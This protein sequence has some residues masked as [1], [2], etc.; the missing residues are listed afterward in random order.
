M[1]FLL[2]S[3]LTLLHNSQQRNLVIAEA[4]GTKVSGAIGEIWNILAQYLNFT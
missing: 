4:N 3:Y 2:I 1:S